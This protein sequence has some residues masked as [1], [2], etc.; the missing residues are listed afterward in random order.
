MGAPDEIRRAPDEIS[1]QCLLLRP[2]T[3]LKYCDVGHSFLE[4]EKCNKMDVTKRLCFIY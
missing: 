2:W 3:Q 4:G 1:S